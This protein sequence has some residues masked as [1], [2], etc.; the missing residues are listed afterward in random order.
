MVIQAA[1]Q[2]RPIVAPSVGLP[3]V[4][5][6]GM[7]T[8]NGRLALQQ[9]RDYVANMSRIVPCNATGT[10]T[11]T[12]TLLDVQPQV[13]QY[14]SYD[15]YAFVAEHDA[16]GDISALV[17][18]AN[19]ALATLNVYKANGAT[20]ATTGDTVAGLQYMLTYADTLNSNAGGFVLR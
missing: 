6:D 12:L 13:N 1:A 19:G 3:F 16:A 4:D 9:L 7:L 14:S 11:I 15:T 8:N 18:T 10:N 17:V 5:Q 20:R 2:P